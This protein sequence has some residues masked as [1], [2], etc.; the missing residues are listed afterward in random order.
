ML[1]TIEPLLGTT[2]DDDK[3]KPAII[4]FYDFTKAGTDIIDQKMGYYTAETKSRRWTMVAF[5]YLLDTIR[6]NVS[7]VL[8]VN[9]KVD[10]KKK[11]S[12][13]F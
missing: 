9:K 4:K 2:I 10:P 7:T 8:A 12:F 5:A 11:E 3:C 1:S 6:V 13:D